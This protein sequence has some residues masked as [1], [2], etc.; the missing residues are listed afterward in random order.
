MLDRSHTTAG[1]GLGLSLVEAISCLHG[2]TLRLDDAEL[3]LKITL[4]IP[5]PAS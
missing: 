1:T 3:G 2:G 5:K 4:S